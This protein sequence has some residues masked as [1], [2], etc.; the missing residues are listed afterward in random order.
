[1]LGKKIKKVWRSKIVALPLSAMLLASTIATPVAIF[2][3]AA[4][5]AQVTPQGIDE[6][7]PKPFALG[8]FQTAKPAGATSNMDLSGVVG[9]GKVSL[10][11]IA[12]DGTL[13]WTGSYQLSDIP[14]GLDYANAPVFFK[15]PAGTKSVRYYDSNGALQRL[16]TTSDTAFSVVSNDTITYIL[17]PIT[18]F[19]QGKVEKITSPRFV[20]LDQ[21]GSA[22]ATKT[23]KS[24]GYVPGSVFTTTDVTTNASTA[25]ATPENIA[26]MDLSGVGSKISINSIRTSNITGQPGTIEW[27]GSYLP[28]DLPAGL[29]Y[30]NVPVFFKAPAGTVSAKYYG[31]DGSLL[32]SYNT[33]DLAFSVVTGGNISYILAGITLANDGKI[34]TYTAP[35]IEFFDANGSVITTKKFRS[36]GLLT[37]SNFLKTDTYISAT[38]PP[39]NTPL[40][41][42]MDL[43]GVGNKMSINSIVAGSGIINWKGD[44]LEGDIPSGQSYAS[45]PV[46]FKAPAGTV[47]A[48]FI[49]SDGKLLDSYDTNRTANSIVSNGNI[50]WVLAPIKLSNNGATVI[51]SNPSFEFYDAK[52]NLIDIKRFKSNGQLPSLPKPITI[53]TIQPKVGEV[54]DAGLNQVNNTSLVVKWSTDNKVTWKD[55]DGL[56]QP[57]T[58]YW[59]R[60][61][62]TADRGFKF[63]ST[64]SKTNITVPPSPAVVSYSVIPSSVNRDGDTLT[65]DVKWAVTG[66][67]QFVDGVSIGTAAPVAGEE[68]AD[69]INT[70]TTGLA[71]TPTV[72]WSKNDGAS[73]SAASGNYAGATTYKTKYVYTAETGYSFKE[74]P[75][76][77]GVTGGV[78]DSVVRSGPMNNILTIIVTW[79]PTEAATLSSI[80]VSSLPYKT[81]Y[82]VGEEL[83]I[84]GLRV[85]G[86]YSDTYTR[87]QTITMANISGFDP[88]KVGTQTI[89]VTV[90]EKTA[91]FD[92]TVSLHPDQVAAN[93]VI[94][95]I[96]ALPTTITL[97]DKEAVNAAE[98][99]YNGLTSAQK[100]LVTNYSK[101]TTALNV[102][103][104][105]ENQATAKVVI[106]QINSL[107]PTIANKAKYIAAQTAYNAL[108]ADQ[109]QLVTN[110]NKVT[111][112][113]SIIAGLEKIAADKT[114]PVISGVVSGKTYKVGTI[115]KY[116]DNLGIKSA[117]LNNKTFVS[118][119]AI[120]VAGTYTLVVT[121]KN[122]NVTTVKFTIKAIPAVPTI[123]TVTTKSTT[124]TGKA[125]KGCT[126]TVKVGTKVYKAVNVTSNGTYTVKI[127]K[128]T[129]NTVITVTVK[130]ALGQTS[131]K[132]YKVTK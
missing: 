24:D 23:F 1:M 116:S 87:F 93:D 107:T 73:W 84:T 83:D 132:T 82:I 21:D 65:I 86:L 115:V 67:L 111:S 127:T 45:V 32:K 106:D 85:S 125:E 130:D 9:T 72:T 94:S 56:Y 43:S 71:A 50:T 91:T 16:Y 60:Y 38:T 29:N 74:N 118:G 3:P 120:K 75:I 22:L 15:A 13:I 46:F 79:N 5:A 27:K 108:S 76:V 2:V 66:A 123:N 20:F 103:T 59:T 58:Q 69:G 61:V 11:N 78:V 121:D 8:E 40:P 53:N 54:M 126:V 62:Y 105:L 102:I 30:A 88:S 17:V 4:H 10:P 41:S 113:L 95:A 129:K 37:G 33:N 104:S 7:T 80:S 48:K 55:T 109:K 19:S 47:S 44:Y 131:T 57:V 70:V 89:T 98:S 128:P 39:D 99:K 52:G 100:L 42:D 6:L 51:Y 63:D 35:R 92:V 18:L 36:D 81:D 77:T 68:M 64:I 101:L 96:N 110:Y 25:G 49:G 14:A 117:L 114:K 12:S 31:S 97:K 90:G 28:S 112:G 124:V 34:E 26:K 119:T 122:N